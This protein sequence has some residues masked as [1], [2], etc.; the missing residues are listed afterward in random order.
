[1]TE[2]KHEKGMKIRREVLGDAHVDRAEQNKTA[3]DADFQAMI[4]E[5]AWGTVWASE[6]ISRKERHMIV[7]ALLAALGKEAELTMHI[8]AT[9]NTGLSPEEVKEV[10]QTVAIYA[11]IP[12]ANT[13]ISIAK[14]VYEE[15]GKSEGDK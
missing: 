11:G 12:A 1:M 4:T 15:L 13:A 10:L 6:G 14:Q 9:Q 8:R 5:M 2:S 7:I 3:L